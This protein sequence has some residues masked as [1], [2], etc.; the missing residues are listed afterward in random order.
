[1]AG[2]YLAFAIVS[3]VL[4]ARETGEGRDIDVTLFD[5]AL[6]NLNY[7]ASWYLNTGHNQGRELRSA[8][9]SLTPC[10]LFKTKDGWIYVMCNKEKFWGELCDKIGRTDLV[11][12]ARFRGYPDRLENRDLLTEIIDEALSE[13]TTDEWMSTFAGAVPAAPLNDVAQA[14]ENPFVTERGRIQ[15]LS[16]PG[17]QK[18]R[19]LATPV[20]LPG[21]IFPARPGPTLGGDTDAVM[22]ELGYDADKRAQ[23]RQN[24]VG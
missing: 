12:D 19:L 17:G 14:L 13:K 10:Q 5:T 21:E 3:G 23:L 9:P 6:Y 11:S 16:Q 2:A 18:F 20:Q 15:E 8:H 7:L 4:S 22:E 24:G 1:M